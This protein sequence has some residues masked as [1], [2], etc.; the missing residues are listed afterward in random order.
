MMSYYSDDD[1]AFEYEEACDASLVDTHPYDCLMGYGAAEIT[2]T[3]L[4]DPDALFAAIEPFLRGSG[5]SSGGYAIKRYGE[6]ADS[7]VRAVRIDL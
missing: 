7:N 5:L 3:M 4:L 2:L 1:M 6:A